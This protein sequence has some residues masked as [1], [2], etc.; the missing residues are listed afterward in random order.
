MGLYTFII[1]TIALAG[2]ELAEAKLERYLRRTNADQ[3]TPV[4]KTDK[5]MARLL[6]DGY[7]IK[8]KENSGGE[9]LVSYRVGPRGKVE[10][11][12]EGVADFVRRV[13]GQKADDELD[14]RLHRSLDLGERRAES[15]GAT[16]RASSPRKKRKGTGR[17]SRG[18]T[19]QADGTEDGIDEEETSE[20]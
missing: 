15:A 8:I 10:V 6:K 13:Y 1:A 20:G 11:G 7:I 19:E 14:K 2:G 4:D 12:D 3:S 16:K 18:Q 5:L 9:E 17:P